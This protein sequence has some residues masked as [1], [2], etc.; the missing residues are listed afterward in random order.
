MVLVF[1]T[2]VADKRD[3]DQ[4]RPVLDQLINP[5]DRWNFD[6]EDCDK[7]LRVEARNIPERMVSAVLTQ[8]GFYCVALED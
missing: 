4:L 1:K 6:L 7:I 5:G 2:S 8:K 3:I